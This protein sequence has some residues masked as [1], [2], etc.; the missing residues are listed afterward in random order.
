M[1]DLS[2]YFLNRECQE[3]M[4]YLLRVFNVHVFEYEEVSMI[5]VQ[6]W[7]YDCYSKLISNINPTKLTGKLSFVSVLVGKQSER[8]N[9]SY[10]SKSL[11]YSNTLL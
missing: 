4:E 6:Y 8:V 7:N 11:S 5:F 9:I 3:V 10:I 1:I 2:P